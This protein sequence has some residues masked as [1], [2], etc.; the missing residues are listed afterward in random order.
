MI[1]EQIDNRR[2]LTSPITPRLHVF[3]FI[4]AFAI[5]ISRRPD[6][7]FNAQFWAEDGK[8]WYASAYNLGIIQSLFLPQSGY[9]QTISRLTGILAQ[10][11]PLALAPLIFN[12]VA[13]VIQILPVTYL[14]SSRFSAA[15]P[16]LPTRLFLCFAYLALPNCFE[17]HANITNAQWHLALL[18]C[19]AVLA[20]PSQNLIWRI[21]DLGVVLL[22][23]L[24]GPF[25][26]LLT[27]IA[28]LRW[29]T[30]RHRWL[31][32]LLLV[33][34]AG[35]LIQCLTLLSN[36]RVPPAALGATP[37]L[38]AKI[39]A[40]Q[41]FLASLV[42]QK[43]YAWIM[44]IHSL[45]LPVTLLA[46]GIGVFAL[47]YALFKAPLELR[48]FILFGASIFGTA[49]AS[50]ATGDTTTPQWQLLWLPGVGGRYWF[51]LMLAFVTTLFW[52]LS[53]KKQRYLR[54]LAT[55]ALAIMLVGI[56]LDWS[57]P[58]FTDFKFRV[59]ANL[60]AQAPKGSKVLIPIN[61]PG[62]NME[63][64]KH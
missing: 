11:F 8:F 12:L 46:L 64:I 10:F 25:S 4:T 28:A 19:M 29:W 42:G 47:L 36:T 17:I 40:G 58:A 41:V 18:A 43:G 45:Y 24:S 21:C 32:L 20:T 35:A 59:H 63:L 48:F 9:L 13:I 55:L 44:P 30:Y 61:P 50:P 49:L 26:I 5:V 54:M 38:F 52:M 53:L 23:S 34:S 2:Q 22:S 57:H 27:P 3:V 51:M 33:L 15:I 56:A 1:A 37:T 6:A 60:F 14:I 16:S 7:L 31:F 39:L 62:W